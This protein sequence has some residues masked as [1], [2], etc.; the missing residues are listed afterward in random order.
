MAPAGT[1]KLSSPKCAIVLAYRKAGWTYDKI[2]KQL[3]VAKSTCYQTVRCYQ[4][5]KTLCSLFRSGRPST[6]SKCGERLILCTIKTHR[7][8]TWRQVAEEAGGYTT[9]QVHG[10]AY[11][12]GYHCYLACHMPFLSAAVRCAYVQWARWN[13]FR[14]WTCVIW[15]DESALHLGEEVI[16]P[17]VTRVE[18]E[19]DLSETMVYAHP[20]TKSGTMVWGCIAYGK[21]GPLVHL[22]L[23]RLK[24]KAPK[25]RKWGG[26]DAEGYV[27]QVLGGPLLQFFKDCEKEHKDCEKEHKDCE[28]EHKDCEKEHKDCEKEHKD[29][30]KEHKDCEKEHDKK[31]LVVEDGA[32]ARKL[33]A[34][35]RTWLGIKHLAHPACPPDLNPIERIWFELHAKSNA[36][37]GHINLS[38]RCGRRQGRLERSCQT[39]IFRG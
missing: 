25:D 38:T 17:R 21:K 30:E 22:D 10:V 2:A 31:M 29:C 16:H 28:K 36:H 1:S 23:L 8:D 6:L 20:D 27:A 13:R 34:E 33:A 37:L 7:F 19:A 18:E 39:R 32:P 3:G 11:Y 35:A 5:Y 12:V 24:G 9:S 26:L 4:L 15:R 14:D